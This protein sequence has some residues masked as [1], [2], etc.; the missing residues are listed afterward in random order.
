M[1]LG[2][3][4]QFTHKYPEVILKYYILLVG[5]NLD[6]FDAVHIAEILEVRI[7]PLQSYDLLKTLVLFMRTNTLIRTF[8]QHLDIRIM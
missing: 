2:L 5:N 3:S 7:E 8:M 6:E 4:S 1:K